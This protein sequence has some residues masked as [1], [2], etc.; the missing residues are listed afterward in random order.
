MKNITLLFLYTFFPSDNPEKYLFCVVIY[1]YIMI[2]LFL[3][4]FLENI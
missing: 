3:T 1:P 4:Q 2:L